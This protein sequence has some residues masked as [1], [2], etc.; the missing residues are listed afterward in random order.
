LYELIDEK[1][2]ARGADRHDR[3]RVHPLREQKRCGGMAEVVKANVV[4][5]RRRQ[6]PLERLIHGPRVK[7]GTGPAR[8]DESVLVPLGAGQEPI[9]AL[10]HPMGT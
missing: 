6:E 3:S 4:Q 7:G 9:L 2:P 10:S 5:A 8:E 1:Y